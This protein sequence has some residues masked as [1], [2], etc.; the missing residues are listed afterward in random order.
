[1]VARTCAVTVFT[2]ARNLEENMPV[3]IV[4]GIR[5]QEVLEPHV[6]WF[7]WATPRNK[8]EAI[9]A[10]I[11]GMRQ[12][13]SLLIYTD[14]EEKNFWERMAQYGVIRRVGTFYRRED[15]VWLVWQEA[16]IK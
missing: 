15:R 6:E 13:T 2:S 7:P 5:K 12:D 4:G 3:G 16:Q 8:V 1:M 9:L 10:Y 11:E 14:L